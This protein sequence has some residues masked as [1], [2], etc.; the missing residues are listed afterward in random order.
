[1]PVTTNEM[2]QAIVAEETLQS[3]TYDI[4]QILADGC[5]DEPIYLQGW[6][7]DAAKV[8]YKA[9]IAL[10]ESQSTREQ[11]TTKKTGSRSS[12]LT[13]CINQSCMSAIVKLST[14]WHSSQA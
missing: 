14:S 4:M 6:V 3:Y 8:S 10:L 7:T 2:R 13:A 1:M 9:M 11:G 12:Y 5:K